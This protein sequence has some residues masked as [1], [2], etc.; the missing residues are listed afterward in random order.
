MREAGATDYGTEAAAGAMPDGGVY[1]LTVPK[2][3][4]RC[5]PGPYERA[6]QVAWYF[7]DPKA[8][9]EGLILD[10]N[11][12]VQSK[13]ALFTKVWKEWYSGILEYRPNSTLADVMPKTL[14]AKLDSRRSKRTCSTSCRPSARQDRA[15]HRPDHGQPTSG[16]GSTSSPT[17]R[18]PR[19]TSTCWATRFWRLPRCPNP[20]TH[21]QQHAKVAAAAVIALLRGE[22]AEP[23]PGHQQHLL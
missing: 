11:D 15:E 7:K 4:Y 21:G 5:P 14:T 12:K 6:C 23:K 20:G 3:P 16:S 19:R 9:G 18:S 22:S 8:E 10:A 2:A 13:E 17:N 1:A